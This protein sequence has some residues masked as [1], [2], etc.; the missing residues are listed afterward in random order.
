MK[1]INFLIER[2]FIS[3]SSQAR[4]T[5]ITKWFVATNNLLIENNK[6]INSTLIFWLKDYNIN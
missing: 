5:M 3:S 2:L 6:F 4:Q 1:I